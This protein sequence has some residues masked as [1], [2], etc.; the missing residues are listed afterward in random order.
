MME[1]GGDKL[2]PLQ[3][4]LPPC[5]EE[6][7]VPTILHDDVGVDGGV[8]IIEKQMRPIVTMVTKS[9]SFGETCDFICIFAVR[10][11]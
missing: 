5:V 7:V 1:V 3:A 6:D 10:L 9:W 2:A 11:R 8:G 4:V